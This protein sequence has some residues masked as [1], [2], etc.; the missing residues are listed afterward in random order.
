LTVATSSPKH[1]IY[2]WPLVVL[3]LVAFAL[4][5]FQLASQSLWYDEG[6]TA[7]VTRQPL[8]ELTAW[9][10]ND[11]QPPL[12]YY[13]LALWGQLVGWSEFA[14]RF[15][16]VMW[17]VV[18]VALLWAM[19]SVWARNPAPVLAAAIA[20]VS[21]L[22]VYY[23]QEARMYSM[24]IALGVTCGWL[25]SVALTRAPSAR[26][27]F[28]Y[29]FFATL[30]VYTHYFAFFLL[31]ALGIAYLVLFHALH[32]GV[33]RAPLFG[34]VLSQLALL[35]LYIPWMGVMATRLGADSS[36]WQGE[37]KV[38]EA[39]RHAAISFIAGE[40]ILE[41]Q[42]V[43]LALAG[44]LLTI[45]VAALAW[46]RTPQLRPALTFG[47]LWFIIPVIGVVTLAT[48]APKFN[49]RYVLIS[50]PGLILLWSVSICTLLTPLSR[51]ASPARRGRLWA[52]ALLL[53]I[54]ASSAVANFNWFFNNAFAKAQ[55]RQMVE[56][57]RPRLAPD[58]GVILVSGHAWPV[59]DYYAPDLPALRLPG[60]D[61]LDVDEVLTFEN[62]AAPLRTLVERYPGAW[63]ALWQEEVVDPNDVVPVQLEL[64]GREKGSSALFNQLTLRRFSRLRSSRIADQPPIQRPLAASF[65]DRL[66]LNG[67]R[68]L[69]N[70]DLL[71]FW[72]K[73]TSLPGGSA[74]EDDYHMKVEVFDADG[75]QVASPPDRRLAGYNYP[76]FRWQPGD[77]VMG[78]I[79]AQEWLGAEPQPGRY[80][81]RLTVYD[82]ND[83]AMTPLATENGGDALVIDD[84]E[85]VIE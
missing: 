18:V 71:F 19:T 51:Q 37:F 10:A 8:A 69:G 59:W 80:T 62:T 48:F 46:R 84:V 43:W 81:V 30:A 33:K 12:F 66:T 15:P 77:V 32:S 13:S 82:A 23:S 26:L 76:S 70:G 78:R 25:I 28:A 72:Q 36:Y 41:R 34:F 83:P 60:I 56:F 47:L 21:P 2:R 3:L 29:T 54:M 57:L 7:Y 27:W 64:S 6:V 39:L 73:K 45:V 22:L 68:S 38:G 50:A 75:Q 52:Y 16:S 11:I 85:V 24:L 49:A 67:L 35:V 31:L 5:V 40:T 74:V 79:P 61:V 63:L 17:G 4:R 42:A 58:E 9:T 44:A 53:C 55:W 20:A 1:K 65:G 14:L